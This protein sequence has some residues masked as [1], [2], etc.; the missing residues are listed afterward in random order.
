FDRGRHAILAAADII[1]NLSIGNFDPFSTANIGIINGG[2][3]TTVVPE[4]CT[5]KGNC[6]SFKRESIDNFF[7]ELEAL[8]ARTD[9]SFRT[10]TEIKLL[11]YFKGF[12][13]SKKD[14]V[15]REVKQ[16]IKAAG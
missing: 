13:I 14:R 8:I 6:Y 7:A 10:T 2:T 4:T 1:N 3:A 5:F 15:V 11:E 12:E 16:S 9:K